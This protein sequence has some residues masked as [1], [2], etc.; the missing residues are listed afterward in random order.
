MAYSP[1]DIKKKIRRIT[2]NSIKAFARAIASNLSKKRPKI[3]NLYVICDIFSLPRAAGALDRQ[4]IFRI[5][6]LNGSRPSF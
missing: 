2:R 4:W 3:T 5:A 1:I 6:T